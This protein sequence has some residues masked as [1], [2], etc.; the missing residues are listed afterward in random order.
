M[1]GK[2]QIP[3]FLRRIALLGLSLLSYGCA[4]LGSPT[5]GPRDED[6]PQLLSTTPIDQT[7][8][9]RG[10]MI[11]LTFN[12]W[13]QA[14]RLNQN[15][16]IAPLTDQPYTYKVKKN[17]LILEFE[18]SLDTNTTYTLAFGEGIVD[19]TEKN[20]ARNVKLA[21]STGDFIDSLRLHGT[22]RD[23]KSGEP[24]ESA[25]VMLYD[26]EDSLDIRSDKP[27]YL[28]QSDSAGHYELTNLKAGTYRAYALKEETA[29]FI[30]DKSEEQ[31][32]FLDSAIRITSQRHEQ[33][34]GLLS[35]D[36]D[37]LLLRSVR[38]NRQ[39]LE[40]KFSK[41]FE[42]YRVDFQEEK[43]D[44]L[45][46]HRGREEYIT[47]FY[48]QL[49]TL[50]SLKARIQ[51]RD[52]M[53]RQVDTTLMLKFEPSKRQ[54]EVPFEVVTD[55]TS[56]SKLRPGDSVRTNLR[57]TKPIYTLQ[58]DSILYKK[59]RD[60][61][62]TVV[63]DSARAW[64][65]NR[66]ELTLKHP[67]F[68]SVFNWKLKL[69]AFISVE[70]DSTTA[71]ETTYTLKNPEDFGVIRGSV[72][73]LPEGVHF[74]LQLIDEQ[75]EVEQELYDAREFAFTFVKPG[76]KYFRVLHDKNG[77]GQWDKGDIRYRR[78][79]EPISFPANKVELKANW[80]IED[81]TIRL[82]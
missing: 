69:A 43:Y 70:N 15:L 41:P 48:H 36:L 74:I 75:G 59:D 20:K 16:Q 9:F 73:G 58:P 79:P 34:F 37:T 65:H 53:G 7:T 35:Y 51:A 50:D 47:F 44:T 22:V 52:L 81:E 25:T 78:L 11:T 28:T 39:L 5:G 33:N 14:Q 8:N 67:P 77:N 42:S 55:P 80:E 68:D 38:P 13:I 27:L 12:E 57:F 64:N 66:T 61:L 32:A 19:I 60:T 4:N 56:G 29:N 26:A 18:E 6:P 17:V 3:I 30:Y 76:T 46:F 21:F 31:I 72:T 24:V 1:D 49:D 23:Y 2:Q 62:Y 10:N 71:Q 40:A 82:Q 54:R 63:S 45:V